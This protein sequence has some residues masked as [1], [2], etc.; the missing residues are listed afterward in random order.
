MQ[1][2]LMYYLHQNIVHN[3]INEEF[4][5]LVSR[6]SNHRDV[7]EDNYSDNTMCHI[8]MMGSDSK[9][10]VVITDKEFNLMINSDKYSSSLESMI[11]RLSSRT[12]YKDQV[13][14]SN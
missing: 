11:S 5:Q 1:A 10:H 4:S 9:R 12:F 13:I 3:R 2:M 8:V 6:G 14:Q 7:L